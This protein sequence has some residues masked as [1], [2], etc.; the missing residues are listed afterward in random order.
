M[1][2]EGNTHHNKTQVASYKEQ[3]T[4]LQKWT[5]IHMLNLEHE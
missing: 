1:N 5:S 4:Q 3:Q 2:R